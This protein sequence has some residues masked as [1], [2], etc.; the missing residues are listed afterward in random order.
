MRPR[1]YY[2]AYEFGQATAIIE[3]CAA[4]RR[5]HASGG[6]TT[7]LE[8][9]EFAAWWNYTHTPWF[10]SQRS[11]TMTMNSTAATQKNNSATVI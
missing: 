2:I 11:H 9:E 5:V 8:A 4:A 6:F 7:R 10:H 3:G 1:K